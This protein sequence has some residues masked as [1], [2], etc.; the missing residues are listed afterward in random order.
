MGS[1]ASKKELESGIATYTH[2]GVKYLSH[3]IAA[4]RISFT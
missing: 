4:V 2:N 1:S 3:H